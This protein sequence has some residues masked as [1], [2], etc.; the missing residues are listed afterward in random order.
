MITVS[1]NILSEKYLNFLVN[2]PGK[3]KNIPKTLNDKGSLT[4]LLDKKISPFGCLLVILYGQAEIHR[5]V[6]NNCPCSKPITDA[7]NIP[8]YMLVKFVVRLQFSK[9]NSN[10]LNSSY[11]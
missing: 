3:N 6:I 1:L 7:I 5:L 8:L 10:Y 4:N 11:S 9:L 2:Y